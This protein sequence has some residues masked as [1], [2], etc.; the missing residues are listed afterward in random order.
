MIGLI[1][2]GRFFDAEGKRITV[3]A[4]STDPGAEW[5]WVYLRSQAER[6]GGSFDYVLT[7]PPSLAQG[8]AGAGCDGYG[9][10]QRWNLGWDQP[11]R[12][13][14][15]ED[16][17]AMIA[18]L[19]AEGTKT[20]FDLVLH[21]LLGPEKGGPGVSTYLGPDGKTRNGR[22]AT[23]PG[24]FRGNTQK[25]LDANGNWTGMYADPAPPFCLEDDVPNRGSDMPFGREISYQHC[26]P[27]GITLTDAM[28]FILW[29]AD[30]TGVVD[31]RL[32]DVKGTYTPAISVLAKVIL[33]LRGS[34]FGE[35]DDN[36]QNALGWATSSPMK[37]L[38]AIED[39]DWHFRLQAACNTFNALA[40]FSGGQ[41][42]WQRRPDLAVL[43]VENAD[44]DT[45]PGQ[46]I[47]SNKVIAYAITLC[48]P[49]RESQVYGPDY[50]PASV[51]PGSRGLWSL[52]DNLC[53][54]AR[55]FA[56]GGFQQRWLDADVFAFTRDGNGGPLGW[57]GGLLIVTNFN[58][59]TPRPL[60]LATMW[61][62]GTHLHDYTGNHPDVWVI[63]NGYVM[64][65]A[66]SNAYS[67]GANSLAFSPA[68]VDR[69]FSNPPR[70]TTQTF[71][72]DGT[73]D[74]LQ[75]KNGMMNLPQ[76]VWCA[77][78]TVTAKLTFLR[79]GLDP[80][81]TVQLE[82][83]EPTGQQLAW[84]SS[85]QT[86]NAIASAE[87]VEKGWHTLRLT[88]NLLP[89]AGVSFELAVTYLGGV[90]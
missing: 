21:Q 85:G 50:F 82:I 26:D 69:P 34:T 77:G 5:L 57:S 66:P 2:W 40:L 18:A 80:N 35:F 13:G 49:A 3:P 81:A 12:Y 29:I 47:V 56:I 33:A 36:T 24:W 64:C 1:G 20:H 19:S 72:G 52:L 71:V 41:C 74:V 46:Q 68:G 43:F 27:P 42:A 38:S 10:A 83:L 4:P 14:W 9:V 88:S 48:L 16:L 73:I 67:S 65:T 79:T 62:E 70:T 22:G 86:G 30:R 51:W 37:G 6:L 15:I 7:P 75:M 44:T 39:F 76:R 55:M 58:V 32:D 53:W 78:G 89:E 28:D 23:T 45:S 63:E 59:L 60:T 11:T 90:A 84:A 87:V 8:G 54:I 61:P 17:L 31:F 25:V